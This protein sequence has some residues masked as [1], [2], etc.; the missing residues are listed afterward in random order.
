MKSVSAL[1]LSF[2]AVS[3]LLGFSSRVWIVQHFLSLFRRAVDDFAIC[4]K[5][6]Y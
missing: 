5:I 2:V 1:T 3:Y 4:E 6:S